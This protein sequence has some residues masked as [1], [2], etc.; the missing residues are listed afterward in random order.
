MIILENKVKITGPVSVGKLNTFLQRQKLFAQAL[1]NSKEIMAVDI[2]LNKQTE[3]IDRRGKFLIINLPEK[4]IV[5]CCN[6]LTEAIHKINELDLKS[7][8]FI[9]EL[10]HIF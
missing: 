4:K 9:Y 5:R 3:L 2:L 1:N 7:K 8:S 10:P 6:T